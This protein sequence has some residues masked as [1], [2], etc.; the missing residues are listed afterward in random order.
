MGR[1]LKLIGKRFGKLTVI[2]QAETKDHRTYWVCQCDCGRK[3]TTAGVELNRGSTKSC[4]LCSTTQ[5]NRKNTFKDISGQRF[6][7]LIALK[8][9]TK[10]SNRTYKWLCQC[11]CGNFVEVRGE[12]LR[13]GATQSCGCLGK[14]QGED[15]IAEILKQNNILFQREYVFNDCVFPDTGK[16][17]RFDFFIDHSYI[18][19]YDGKQHFSYNN[20][21]WNNQFNFK[22]LKKR[23]IVF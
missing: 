1:E 16:V 8:P 17:A 14:S 23:L 4:G 5:Q 13:N 22:K 11:D 15:K 18:V 3:I 6:G 2:E 12:R 10:A 9:T 20:Q 19:Q 7:R 21:G